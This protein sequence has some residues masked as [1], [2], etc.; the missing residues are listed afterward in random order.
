M[1]QRTLLLLLACI[2]AGSIYGARRPK[3]FNKAPGR[4]S[5]VVDEGLDSPQD[6]IRP[7]A[8]E[9]IAS[10]ILE[11][12]Q[13][14][15]SMQR[16]VAT[17]F[18]ADSMD[19]AGP[20]V[21]FKTVVHA[22]A[23]HRPLVFS[24]D[25]IWLLISQGF[26]RYVNAHPEQVRHLLVEHEGKQT[27]VVESQ[28]DLLTDSVDWSAVI[29]GFA[30][31]I[32]QHTKADVAETL[33]ADFSTTG[34]TERIAS[35]ITLM[36]CV[37][38][39]FEY[40]VMR[41]ACGIP[42]VTLLGTPADWEQVQAKTQQLGI[43]GLQP[44]V[45]EL[46]PILQ[47]FVRAAEG[48]PDQAFWQRMV[49]RQRP[50]R[51]KGGGCVSGKPTQVDGW[52]LKLFPDEEGRTL[53]KVPHTHKMPA[54]WARVGFQY[55]VISPADGIVISQT[56]MELWA[57]FIGM[58]EDQATQALIPLIGWLVRQGDA[59]ADELAQ[60]QEN[61][62]LGEDNIVGGIYIR[63]KEVPEVLAKMPHI[64]SL[65]LCFTGPV[66]LPAWMDAIQIDHLII[67]PEPSAEEQAAIKA[68]FPHAEFSS[69]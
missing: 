56:P 54:E 45:R 60:L 28:K 37:K 21:V 69:W 48:Q 12:E 27:L 58:K 16:V 25:M 17:S 41:V 53:D 59:E 39:Y 20:D 4:I 3:V 34:S 35:G 9:H 6:K 19:W 26:S 23:N 52:L 44:W 51:L 61:A 22:Y 66:V 10:I 40:V 8:G 65:H 33:L 2:V 30:T 68:R 32:R 11:E 36:E 29:D 5:F 38:S 50:D 43:E 63:V 67:A 47:Q 13:V 55:K 62:E 15:Q 42:A 57:G 1:K 14:A 64:K 18:A 7:I 24:P 46:K 31:Q 49:K